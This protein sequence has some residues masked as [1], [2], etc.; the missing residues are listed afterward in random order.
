MTPVFSSARRGW[1]RLKPGDQDGLCYAF[2]AWDADRPALGHWV[3]GPGLP[4]DDCIRGL[5]AQMVADRSDDYRTPFRS[6]QGRVVVGN[7][8]VYVLAGCDVVYL[9]V[10][11]ERR[12]PFEVDPY[13]ALGD[14]LTWLW[15]LGSPCDVHTAVLLNG[16]VEEAVVSLAERP[17]ELYPIAFS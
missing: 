3:A 15:H 9:A 17:P 14:V 11:P 2:A 13:K 5:S 16:Q 7:E 12:S 6:D 4:Y 1:R 8:A 10:D